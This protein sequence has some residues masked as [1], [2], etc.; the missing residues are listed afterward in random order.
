M[1]GWS[2]T[3]CVRRR[4]SPT[5]SAPTCCRIWRDCRSSSA[6]W[7]ALPWMILLAAKAARTRSWK[8]AAQFALIVALV[9][10][11][12]ATSLVL[13]G[14]GP[15]IW[16]ITDVVTKAGRHRRRGSS[17]REDRRAVGGRVDLGIVAL[18]VQGTYGIPILRYTETYQSVAEREHAGRD[19]PRP[20][21]LVLVRRRPA[22]PL[23]G[24]GR[25]RTTTRWH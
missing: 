13:A 3:R 14:L 10:S 19:R 20:R 9:G 12:N 2:A 4:L 7:A 11:V 5:G 8:P 15:V 16:L 18:R 22:R 17:R 23:G 6:P 25:A 1:V 24:A 21:V